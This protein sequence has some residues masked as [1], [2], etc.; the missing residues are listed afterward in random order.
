MERS[1]FRLLPDDRFD[2]GF[3]IIVVD[4]SFISLRTILRRAAPELRKNGHAVCLIKP[5]FEAGRERLGSGGVVRDPAVH[6]AVLFEAREAILELGLVPVGVMA[7]PLIG[8]AGNR[9]F[10]AHVRRGGNAYSDLEVER[11]LQ[12]KAPA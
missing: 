10:F 11:A 6:R 9:E 2:G 8:P 1:N 3:D 7:S 12:G 4:A 5:Q